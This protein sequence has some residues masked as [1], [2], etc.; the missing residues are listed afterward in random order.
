MITRIDG[1]ARRRS[2]TH[3]FP[4][5]FALHR[6][7]CIFHFDTHNSCIGRA[8]AASRTFDPPLPYPESALTNTHILSHV[9]LFSEH[10]R[11]AVPISPILASTAYFMEEVEEKGG[12][13]M[14]P[15]MRRPAGRSYCCHVFCYSGQQPR[16]G[17]GK[18]ITWTK[19]QYFV[20][21]VLTGVFEFKRLALRA[22]PSCS[23]LGMRG[24]N[25]I[26][27]AYGRNQANTIIVCIQGQAPGKK[28]I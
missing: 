17:H 11:L 1:S 10:D 18:I 5:V 24:K 19:N 27:N 26:C 22:P 21:G 4:R 13:R 9:F 15:R 12:R 7:C 23:Y 14:N 28:S 6:A 25:N 20:P 3:V 16:V 2:L 8:S